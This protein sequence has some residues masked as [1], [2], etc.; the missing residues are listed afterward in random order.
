MGLAA[1][2]VGGNAE[3]LGGALV[4]HWHHGALWLHCGVFEG[5]LFCHHRPGQWHTAGAFC[6]VAATDG[7]FDISLV[8]TA[9]AASMHL[10]GIRLPVPAC[11]PV[12]SELFA[13]SGAAV[14]SD[15]RCR[16]CV[17]YH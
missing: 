13:T 9:A 16:W 1:W 15:C 2:V 7:A 12:V 10:C 14:H 17:W 11:L 3:V 4:A 5:V 8:G 6:V